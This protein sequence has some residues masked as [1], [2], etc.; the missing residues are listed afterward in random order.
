VLK[1]VLQETQ[2]A[3]RVSEG[4]VVCSIPPR[5]QAKR[6]E[7][8][9]HLNDELGEFERQEKQDQR[10]NADADGVGF[11]HSERCQKNRVHYQNPFMPVAL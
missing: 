11:G 8:Q 10:H 3:G 9:Q 4:A 2:L 1:S 7:Q 5:S 6:G